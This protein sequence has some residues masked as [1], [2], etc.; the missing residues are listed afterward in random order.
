MGRSSSSADGPDGL[1]L[2]DK[3]AGDS[4]RHAAARAARS[5][6][7]SK[8]GHAG[9][10]DPFATGLLLVLVGRACRTQGWFT[11]LPKEYI[12]TA[13]FGATS[14]TGDPEGEI[15]ETGTAPPDLLDLRTGRITQRPPAFSAV[16]VGGRRAYELARRGEDFETPEREVEVYAFEETGRDGDLVQLRIECSSGTYVRSLVA[17]LGDAYTAQLRRTAVGP[18]R[19]ED[20]DPENVLPIAKALPFLPTI[21]LDP[22]E[23]RLV[24]HGRPVVP[25]AREDLPRWEHGTPDEETILLLDEEGAVALA[26]RAQDGQVKPVVG[27]RG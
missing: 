25:Q 14:T 21:D 8:F 15:T 10:L 4:S 2:V 5:V 17:D 13:R 27:F 3:E 22:E 24:S 11:R 12:A 20:A 7:A 23:A 9:T 18:F 1:I 26:S 19:V 16:H 6:G